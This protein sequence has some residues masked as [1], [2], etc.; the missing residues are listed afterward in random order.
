MRLRLPFVSRTLTWDSL[1][2]DRS[3]SKVDSPSTALSWCHH[4]A[5][6]SKMVVWRRKVAPAAQTV[7]PANRWILRS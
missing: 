1:N 6:L 7:N 4:R 2:Q 3:P 5:A